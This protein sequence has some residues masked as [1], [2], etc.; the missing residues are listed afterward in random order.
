MTFCSIAR[1]SLKIEEPVV[2]DVVVVV[3]V[4]AEMREKRLKPT[5]SVSIMWRTTMNIIH[6]FSNMKNLLLWDTHVL[7]QTIVLL[8]TFARQEDHPEDFSNT[9]PRSFPTPTSF[10]RRRRSN[11]LSQTLHPRTSCSISSSLRV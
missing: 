4:V 3:C 11:S 7:M 6:T 5:P 1:A 8:C 9:S 2:D 10:P